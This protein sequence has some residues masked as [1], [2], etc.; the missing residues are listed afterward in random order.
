[1]RNR[2]KAAGERRVYAGLFLVSSATLL[3]EVL[4]TRIFD[5]LLWPNVSFT[6][7]SCALF[8][9]GLGGMLDVLRPP[10][11]DGEAAQPNRAAFLFACSIWILPLALNVVPFSF[12][13]ASE[14]PVAQILMFLIIYLLLLLPF[15]LSGLCICRVFSA[16]PRQIHRL[17]FWDLAGA[18][19]GSAV[20]IPLLRP[21]GPERLFI[22]AGVV[23]LVAAALFSRSRRWVAAAAAGAAAF[24]VIPAALGGVYLR[25]ALHDDKRNVET[26]IDQGRL[27]YSAWDPVSQISVIDQPS[28][29][30]NPWDRGKKHVAYDGGTQSSNFFRFDGDV[31]ALRR[32]LGRELHYQFWQKGVLASHYLKRDTGYSALIIGSA[33]GQETKAALMYGAA[34]IDAIEMVRTVVQLAGGRYAAYIGHLFNRPEVHPYVDEGRTFLRASHDRYDV[35]QIFSN[36]TSSSVS[37]GSGALIPTYLLTTQAFEEY[38]THLTS[39]GILHINHHTYP[40]MVVTAA[41]AW[42]ALGRSDFRAHVLVADRAGQSGIDADLPTMLIKMSPWTPREVAD[43]ARFFAMPA[44]GE[45]AYEILENPVDRAQGFLPDAFYTGT[46]PATLTRSAGVDLRPV[47]DDWPAFDFMR[48]SLRRLQPDRRVGL[49]PATA[50]LLNRQLRGAGWLPMDTIQLIVPTAAGLLYGVL[51]VLLPLGCSRVGREPW[52]GKAPT[53]I[54]F[55][56]LGIAFVGLEVLFIQVFMQL[57]GYPLYT[58][59]VVIATLL[60]GAGI[61]S[62]TSRRLLGPDAARWS[63]AFGGLLMTGVANWLLYPGVVHRAAAFGMPVRVAVAIALLFPQAYF[64]GMA[65]PLGI[66]ALRSK[67]RGA[68]AWAWSI[69][70]V[71]STLGSVLAIA[72][73]IW[74]GFHWTILLM[75]SVY[76]AAAVVF[77]L[78]RRTSAESFEL[79][80]AVVLEPPVVPLQPADARLLKPV[81]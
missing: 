42:R 25:L 33:G 13:R 35:I 40:R 32:D 34:R 65:F 1:M 31:A 70:G 72:L 73:S 48:R 18:A 8:G 36:Y 20:L 80:D 14:Q 46:L 17:Y 12:A 37:E 53:L 9:L 4:L 22:A 64:M 67:P 62:A 75:L 77:D 21:V 43:L 49:D 45:P 29:N 26:A 78:L 19:A 5:V 30:G 55:A 41:A 61:G 57:I 74:L 44:D 51:F 66:A 68:I 11:A 59:T 10:S 7:I 27:E 79:S 69:N 24:V 39:N 23:A 76:A 81:E 16:S 28:T 15:M 71:C 58:V 60:V 47:T 6:V 3:V 2:Q 38:F 52:P 50:A 56:L 63:V 54:Y